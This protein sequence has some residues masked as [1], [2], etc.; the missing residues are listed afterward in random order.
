VLELLEG[1]SVNATDTVSSNLKPRR[2]F[3]CRVYAMSDR[4]CTVETLRSRL[5]CYG[6]DVHFTTEENESY[7]TKNRRLGGE[8]GPRAGAP[9]VQ[10][11]A[12]VSKYARHAAVVGVQQHGIVRS[13]SALMLELIDYDR[14]MEAWSERWK[15]RTSSSVAESSSS[16][17]INTA[18]SQRPLPEL[19]VCMYKSVS[20]VIINL[21]E[22]TA[23]KECDHLTP[24]VGY[25]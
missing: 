10:D 7:K 23:D 16:S 13:S 15:R 19:P 8:H 5:V 18:G 11:L 6:C 21:F 3:Q 4:P 17:N 24:I 22:E 25:L 1:N 12:Y 20:S 9:F 2:A 14:Q